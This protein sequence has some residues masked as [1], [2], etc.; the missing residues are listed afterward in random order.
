[1]ASL[2]HHWT[3]EESGNINTVDIVGGVKGKLMSAKKVSPGYFGA[4]AVHLSGAEDSYITLGKSVGQFGTSDFTVS[5]WFSTVETTA[6]FDLVGNRTAMSHGNFFCIRM[7]GKTPDKTGVITAE[8]DETDH[9]LNYIG[10][11]SLEDNLNDGE[12]H[13][14]TVVREGATLSLYIDGDLSGWSSGPG[15]AN[16]NNG[17]EFRIGR[18]LGPGI[19]EFSPHALIDDLRIYDGVPEPLPSTLSRLGTPI[20]TNTSVMSINAAG[21]AAI[22]DTPALEKVN[23]TALNILLMPGQNQSATECFLDVYT[24]KGEIF[25]QKSAHPVKIDLAK[26]GVQVIPVTPF[27]LKKGQFIGFRAEGGAI[28]TEWLDGISTH[29]WGNVNPATGKVATKFT[30]VSLGWN[31]TVEKQDQKK[32]PMPIVRQHLPGPSLPH[33]IFK[34]AACFVDDYIYMIGGGEM[35]PSEM[36]IPH[37]FIRLS[38]DPKT[39]HPA[40]DKWEILK[41]LPRKRYGLAATTVNGKI[42]AFG[43]GYY[44]SFS[45]DA[46]R[47]DPKTSAWKSL[48]PL[49]VAVVNT[50]CAAIDNIIYVV[51]GSHRKGQGAGPG[52]TVF[53]YDIAKNTWTNAPE[54]PGDKMNHGCVA[55]GRNIYALGGSGP[56]CVLNVDTQKWDTLPNWPRRRVIGEAPCSS[57]CVAVHDWIFL[58]GGHGAVRGYDPSS[59][60]FNIKSKKWVKLSDGDL[61]AAQAGSSAVGMGND[62]V[63][64]IYVMGGAK[65]RSNAHPV[66]GVEYFGLQLLNNQPTVHKKKTAK[67]ARGKQPEQTPFPDIIPRSKEHPDDGR[68]MHTLTIYHGDDRKELENV[69]TKSRRDL[70][71]C[72]CAITYASKVTSK[73]RLKTKTL[74]EYLLRIFGLTASA[75]MKYRDQPT[76]SFGTGFRV[77]QRLICTNAHVIAEYKPGK[78]GEGVATNNVTDLSKLRVVFGWQTSSGAAPKKIDTSNIYKVKKVKRW[79]FVAGDYN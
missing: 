48:K 62:K 37:S 34:S 20:V 42:F 41:E 58:L 53:A 46:H 27:P 33:A 9:G 47:Y 8:I 1:M 25:A 79:T 4:N 28:H 12:W 75:S 74:A 16:I 63:A 61:A 31:V 32:W 5:F 69:A 22:P 40:S 52:K 10:V 77:G 56:D 57:A 36:G 15:I 18:S 68:H 7:I 11:E 19:A 39:L 44:K 17:N 43:G 21:V 59:W 70:A 73:G 23:V 51:G 2:T 3:F 45:N 14:V 78:N 24:K 60:G 13:N 38:I 30:I 66:N 29:V 6:N 26:N 64:A 35:G 72:T 50:A 49:P 67:G 55:I 65:A 71:Q 54:L 76:L